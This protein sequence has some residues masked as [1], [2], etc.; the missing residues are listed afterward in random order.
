MYVGLLRQNIAKYD[1]SSLK[2][3]VSGGSALPKE[4]H[5][6]FKK[7]T[8]VDITEGYGLTEA[9]PVT[10]INPY[11]AS[12][13]NS[14]GQPLIDTFVKIVDTETLEEIEIGE[15]GEI[16]ISGP[17]IMKGYWRKGME[18][19]NVFTPENWL[20]TGDLAYVDSNDYFFIVDRSKDIINSG[21]LKVYPREV[22]ELLYK[23]PKVSLA[24]VIPFPD[25][26][27]GE[28]GKA[29]IV[30]KEGQNATSEEFKNYCIEQA[31]T[32]YK[33]PKSFEFIEELPLSAAGKVLKRELVEK[34]KA[35]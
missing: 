22:E 12:K 5:S 4:V 2:V 15:V 8:G 24:A 34:E 27:F 18:S 21:G 7:A 29:F 31:L 25:D 33:I 35:K 23:H 16:I 30:L 28:V 3:C 32:K 20:R 13:T 17:Q 14:I 1:T 19:L 6:E 9:S 11:G 26:Y 10:H